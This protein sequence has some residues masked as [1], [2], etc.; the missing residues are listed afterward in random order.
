MALKLNN[1]FVRGFVGEDAI[2]AI[3]PEVENALE[4]VKNK[5]GAGNDFLGWY[6]LPIAY[7]REEY[8]RI[9]N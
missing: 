1:E 7:D 2:E 9:K 3:R 6:D 8:D 4:T 5:T